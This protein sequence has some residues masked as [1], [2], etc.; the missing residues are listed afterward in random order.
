[1]KKQDIIERIM[2]LR[3][4]GHESAEAIFTESMN[5]TRSGEISTVAA[6]IHLVEDESAVGVIEDLLKD[7]LVR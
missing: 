2:F 4:L 6:S 7:D 5:Q 3:G 1:M